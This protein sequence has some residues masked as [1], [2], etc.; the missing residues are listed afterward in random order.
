MKKKWARPV[1][2]VLVRGT[3][4]ESVLVG[5]KAMSVGASSQVTDGQ[6]NGLICWTT[7]GPPYPID[8]VPHSHC[9]GSCNADAPS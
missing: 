9:T 1:L 8:Y 3:S 4:A 2:I 6:C 5:C 7:H